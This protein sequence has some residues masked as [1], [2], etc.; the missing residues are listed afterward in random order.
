MLPNALQMRVIRLRHEDGIRDVILYMHEKIIHEP[1]DPVEYG[2]P[3]RWSNVDDVELRGM[4]R[5][6]R[7]VLDDS[8]ED[9]L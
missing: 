7:W 4:I 2:V 1:I 5:A 3:P 9:L 6:L 8:D